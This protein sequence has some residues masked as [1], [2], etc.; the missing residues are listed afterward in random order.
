MGAPQKFVLR[1]GD[2]GKIIAKK[3]NARE[4]VYHNSVLHDA[5]VPSPTLVRKNTNN[6]Y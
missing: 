5:C 3:K 6:I 4:K 1:V 2:S